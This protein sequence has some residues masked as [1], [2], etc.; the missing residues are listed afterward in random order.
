M[1]NL[2]TYRVESQLAPFLIISVTYICGVYI[3]IILKI[4]VSNLV[5]Q[6]Q[7]VQ[8]NI[9]QSIEWS[10]FYN[11]FWSIIFFITLRHI[12]QI[13]SILGKILYSYSILLKICAVVYQNRQ[14]GGLMYFLSY[15]QNLAKF[16]IPMQSSFALCCYQ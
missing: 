13:R 7:S 9:K 4:T 6:L 10:P 16:S 15:K 1:F 14:K 12:H 3:N 8:Q 2:V 5:Y 11:G